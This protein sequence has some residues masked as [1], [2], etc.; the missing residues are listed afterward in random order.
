MKCGEYNSEES[1]VKVVPGGT[2]KA[3]LTGENVASWSYGNLPDEVKAIELRYDTNSNR[4]EVIIIASSTAK[5]G[6]TSVVIYAY[7][8]VGEA[9]ETT[10]KITIT[11]DSESYADPIINESSNNSVTVIPGG[12]SS[13]IFTGENVASWSYGN[14]PDEVKAIVLRYGTNPNRCE[15]FVTASSTAKAG[16]TSITIYAYNE[17]GEATETTLKITITEDTPA[18]NPVINGNKSVTV[19][20]G[21]TSKTTFTGQNITAWL[22]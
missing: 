8:E 16:D 17:V 15:V 3:V 12:T 21:G 7:N 11:E 5:A 2:A 18:S 9:T 10:L 19:V 13:T 20:P 4:C 14:L 6:D 1:S 22:S